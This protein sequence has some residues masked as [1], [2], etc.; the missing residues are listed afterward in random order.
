VR[1]EAAERAERREE[2]KMATKASSH[3]VAV[4]IP[5]AARRMPHQLATVNATKV[6]RRRAEREEKKSGERREEDSSVDSF[7]VFVLRRFHHVRSLRNMIHNTWVSPLYAP[8]YCHIP[9]FFFLEREREKEGEA[10][11]AI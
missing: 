9:L 11:G 1:I 7:H 3:V 5:A 2:K 6:T 4:E 8:L 10:E